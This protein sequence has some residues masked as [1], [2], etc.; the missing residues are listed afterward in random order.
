MLSGGR[1]RPERDEDI[2]YTSADRLNQAPQVMMNGGMVMPMRYAEGGG[3]EM[4]EFKAMDGKIN[5]PG[6]ETSD[7][8]PAMLSDGEFV[9][10][11]Q[12]VRGA[13]AFDLSKGDGGII[14]LKPNGK[15]SRE[16]GTQIMY[17]MMDMFSNQARAS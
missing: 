10:K 8:I 15:E 4:E 12:A 6:T 1:K 5:G 16:R 2:R 11:A 7:D 17:Q 14:T 3:V 9:M 13:G